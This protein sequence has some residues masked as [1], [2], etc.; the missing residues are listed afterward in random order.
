MEAIQDSMGASLV[1]LELIC[2]FLFHLAIET[3]HAEQMTSLVSCG[4]FF[5]A[6][7]ISLRAV[8]SLHGRTLYNTPQSF[9]ADEQ[10]LLTAGSI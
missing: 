10:T 1:V 7:K 5:P 9:V 3:V 6:Q 8:V 4:F 2:I